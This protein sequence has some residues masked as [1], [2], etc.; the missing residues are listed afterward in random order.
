MNRRPLARKAEFPIKSLRDFDWAAFKDSVYRR[1]SKSYAPTI[2][3]YSKKYGYLLQTG[4][5]G[6]VELVPASLRNNCIKSLIVLSK[7]LGIHEE[8]KSGLKSYGIKLSR[9]D[10]FSAFTRIY[11]NNNS[12]LNEWLAQVKPVLKNI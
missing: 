9:P 11:G 5:L 8:F 7:F 10:A 2:M 3:H 1:Y 6:E 4:N 12:N